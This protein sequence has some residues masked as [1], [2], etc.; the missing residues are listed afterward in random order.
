MRRV[1]IIMHAHRVA[2]KY[3][4]DYE[5]ASGVFLRRRRLSTVQSKRDISTCD[6]QLNEAELGS[7]SWIE[8]NINFF[9]VN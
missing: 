9:Y 2:E 3:G 8:I 5:I 1:V 6:V 7:S 4:A